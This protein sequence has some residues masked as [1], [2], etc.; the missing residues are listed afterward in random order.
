MMKMIM[1]VEQK[2]KFT[3]KRHGFTGMIKI[4][5]FILHFLVVFTQGYIISKL[6]KLKT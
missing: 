6:M 3:G 2:R 5:Y 4:F 1:M